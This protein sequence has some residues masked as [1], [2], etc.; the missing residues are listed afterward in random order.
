[1]TVAILSVMHFVASTPLEDIVFP[2][3][4]VELL[5]VLVWG[6]LSWIRMPRL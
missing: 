3:K 6:K 4:H 2:D 5:D 1:M